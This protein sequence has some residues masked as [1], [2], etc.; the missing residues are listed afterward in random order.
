MWH[1]AFAIGHPR[2]D[3]EHQELF[4]RLEKLLNAALQGEASPAVAEM[5]DFLGFYVANHFAHEEELME[6]SNYEGLGEHRAQH[7]LFSRNLETL[8]REFTQQGA[9]GGA[10]SHLVA[11][12]TEWLT[13]HVLEVD[14]VMGAHL[15]RK[16]IR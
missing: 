10:L 7:L 16:G 4:D 11:E 9:Y 1:P 12:L 6:W 13:S 2:I 5:L 15:R 14:Q 3:A 8:K